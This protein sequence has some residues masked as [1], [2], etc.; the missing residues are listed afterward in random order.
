[1]AARIASGIA[2]GCRG[3]VIETGAPLPGEASPSFRNIA[4]GGFR[5]VYRRPN[6][7]RPPA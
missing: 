7:Q 6:L 5:E 4:R 2:E 3:F 1:M